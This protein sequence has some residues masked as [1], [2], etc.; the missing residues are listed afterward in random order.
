MLQDPID[1]QTFEQD[2]YLLLRGVFAPEEIGRLRQA[3]LENRAHKGDL[4]SNPG[5]RRVLVDERVLSV[6][7][8]TL[9]GQP[10]YFG[11]SACVIGAQGTG[12]HKDNVDREDPNGPDWRGPYPLVR[13][14][15]YLQDHESHSGGLAVR[16]GSHLST[17]RSAGRPT[18]VA[19]RVGDLVV[20][21]MRITHSGNMKRLKLRPSWVVPPK[22]GK[23]LPQG[24]CLPP[25]GERAALFAAFGLAGPALDRFIAYLKSRTYA[26]ERW[27]ASTLDTDAIALFDGADAELRDIGREIVGVSGLGQQR[28]HAPLPY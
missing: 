5:L 17:D 12:F 14:G 16:S 3:A 28:L 7:R 27:R 19:T 11:D 15:I 1:L 8:A 9:G 4:L 18:N 2:G 21:N 26:V 6:A 25:D 23:R 22:L 24:L 13:M 20:W 10:V